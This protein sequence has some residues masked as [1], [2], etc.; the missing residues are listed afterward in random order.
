MAN[1]PDVKFVPSADSP[2]NQSDIL[3]GSGIIGRGIDVFGEYC[4]GS[5]LKKKIIDIGPLDCTENLLN[6]RTSKLVNVL[7]DKRGHGE[8]IS[9]QSITQFYKEMSAQVKLEGSYGFFKGELAASFGSSERRTKATNFVQHNLVVRS[10]GIDLPSYTSLRGHLTKAAR[11]DFNK[12]P[13]DDLVKEYG[14][15]YLSKLFMGAR[16]SYACEIESE[17]YASD[18]DIAVAAKASFE[19][20]TASASIEAKGD[21]KTAMERLQEKAKTTVRIVGGDPNTIDTIMHGDLKTWSN[22]VDDNLQFYDCSDGLVRI[23]NLVG[24]EVRKKEID[25]AIDAHLEEHGLPDMSQLVPIYAFHAVSSPSRWYFSQDANDHPR[26]FGYHS[27]P[28]YGLKDKPKDGD[29]N[30]IPIYRLSAK[31]PDRYMLSTFNDDRHG[32]ANA[33]LAFYAYSAPSPQMQLQQIHSFTCV[34]T[35]KKSGWYYSQSSTIG[36]WNPDNSNTFFVPLNP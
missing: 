16:C 8:S 30:V 24:D 19:N 23:S 10:Y 20:L 36:G 25:D 34:N 4:S 17:T 21:V 26:G 32:W 6:K 35:P 13:A 22:S 31:N 12:M 5:S 2:D 3:P 18:V 29:A 28:F 27:T 14:A 9:G 11:K 15:F 1:S 33:E 7:P